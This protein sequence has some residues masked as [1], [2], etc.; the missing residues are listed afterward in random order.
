MTKRRSSKSNSS[1][2]TVRGLIVIVAIVIVFGFVYGWDTVEKAIRQAAGLDVTAEPAPPPEAPVAMEAPVAGS[3][4]I[5]NVYFTDPVIPF[6]DVITG[7]I[8]TH[9]VSLI[10]QAESSI[11]MAVFEFNLQSVADALVAAHKRGVVVRVVYDDEH[12]EDDPQIE[13]LI[14]AGIPATPDERSAFMHNKFFVFDRLIVWTG[15][16][17]VTVNGV[18]RNNNNAIAIRSTKLA[19]NYTAE[20]EEMFGG[21][22]GPTSPANTPN[23]VFTL[24]GVK[25]ES[26]FSPEDEPLIRL[27]ER[28][29]EAQKSIHFMAFSFTDYDLALAMMQRAEQGVEVSGIFESVGANTEYSECNT[30]LDAG[31]DVRLDGNPRTF[32]HKVVIIDGSIVAIGSFNFSTNAAESNDENL[33][34][35]H[36]SSVAA[37]YEA[38]FNRR[39]AEA[40][41]PVGGVCLSK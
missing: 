9:L 41:L 8:D 17:N 24:D 21:Q 27:I 40:R 33:L 37:Q 25:F 39:M 15:S 4:T 30:L 31:L 38:E 2:L 14:A 32:H 34:I 10:D 19:E 6:D 26:Y 20:F 22:F 16:M 36:D 28:T 5:F 1:A 12:T 11:D 23:P 35:I 7:G 18:Y 3:G 13:Q 29:G